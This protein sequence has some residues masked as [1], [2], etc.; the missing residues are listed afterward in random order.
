MSG[1]CAAGVPCAGVPRWRVIQGTRVR[2]L[3]HEHALLVSDSAASFQY[4][5][6]GGNP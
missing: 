5:Q 3:C 2:L 6:A 4:I 1:S